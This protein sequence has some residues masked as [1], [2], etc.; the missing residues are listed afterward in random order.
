M[1]RR[2]MMMAQQANKGFE[3]I[4]DAAIGKIP[5][6]TEWS[7]YRF[8]GGSIEYD[9]TIGAL[10]LFTGSS[11][12]NIGLMPTERVIGQADN[13]LIS[14]VARIGYYWWPS[15]IIS[16]TD[17]IKGAIISINFQGGASATTTWNI[18]AW[19]GTSK[20]RVK[21]FAFDFMDSYAKIE[22][23][24]TGNTYTLYINDEEIYIGQAI[25]YT[26]MPTN[27]QHNMIANN[28]NTYGQIFVTNMTYKEW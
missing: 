27:Y 12:S 16:A 15:F 26:D 1:N 25:N 5:P 10:N 4:Y 22:L 11:G 14:T 21:N 20:V 6:T 3:L 2:R 23:I 8:S 17:G 18:N 28:C 19:I 9:N 13:I 24:L 7:S